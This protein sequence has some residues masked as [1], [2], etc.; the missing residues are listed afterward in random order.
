MAPPPTKQRH[1]R[2]LASPSLLPPLNP[3]QQ[4]SPKVTSATACPA[5]QHPLLALLDYLCWLLPSLPQPALINTCPK[6]LNGFPVH[7]VQVQI[8]YQAGKSLYLTHLLPPLFCT[9]DHTLFLIWAAVFP[10]WTFVSAVP[11]S[12]LTL[13][14]AS[15]LTW[16]SI[17]PSRKPS[18]IHSTELGA[19][20]M[21]SHSTHTV[22]SLA[23]PQWDSLFADPEHPPRPHTLRARSVCV[24]HQGKPQDTTQCM[25]E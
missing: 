25:A 16:T 6:A 12:R 1:P 8:P 23:T 20:A 4:L 11:S 10:S 7:Q 15:G 24:V 18:R 3:I 19:P 2:S 13:A 5:H 22:S 14:Y 21:C 9:L 17:T